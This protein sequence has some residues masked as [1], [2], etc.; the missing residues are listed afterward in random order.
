MKEVAMGKSLTERFAEQI[1]LG[2]ADDPVNHVLDLMN[3][4]QQKQASVEMKRLSPDQL[5]ELRKKLAAAQIGSDDTSGAVPR[6]AES[7]TRPEGKASTTM[8]STGDGSD[9][10]PTGSA[11]PSVQIT[12]PSA[13]LTV[14][15][16]LAGI[17]SVTRAPE[18]QAKMSSLIKRAAREGITRAVDDLHALVQKKGRMNMTSRYGEAYTKIASVAGAGAVQDMILRSEAEGRKAAIAALNTGEEV[19]MGSVRDLI[20]GQEKVASAEDFAAFVR[21]LAYND[22]LQKV[23]MLKAAEDALVEGDIEETPEESEVVGAIDDIADVAM[24]NPEALSD[25][26]AEAILELADSLED[27]EIADEGAEKVSTVLDWAAALRQMGY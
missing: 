10:P 7:E 2:S 20:E 12:P 3:G 8:T 1:K 18:G 17:E 6:I 27:E 13:D 24:D 15:D 11:D 22:T 14:E 25:E 5:S 16:L 9:Q 21:Q 26:D 4:G 23:A 19:K